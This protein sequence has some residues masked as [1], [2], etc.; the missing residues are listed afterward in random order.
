M[1]TDGS[2]TVIND[3]PLG[4]DHSITIN[5]DTVRTLAVADFSF[6]DTEGNALLEVKIV[7]LPTHGTIYYDA[8]GAGANAPVAI[9]AGQ[10]FSAA[11]L[12][13]GK[14]TYV[15]GQDDNGAGYATFTYQVRDNGGTAHGGFDTDPVPN[16][17]TVNV[18][19][20]ND[21]ATITGTDTGAVVESGLNP[22]NTP[23]PGTPTATGTLTVTDVDAG[24]NEL[25]PVT[26][27]TAGANGYGTF[28]VAANGTWTY[29]LDNSDSDTNKLFQGQVV[30]DSILVFSKDGTASHTVTV[31]ITGTNDAPDAVNDTASA[32]EDGAL[33]LGTVATNDTDVDTGATRTFAQVGTTPGLTFNSDG[34]YIFN[35]LDPAY[36]HIA[37]GATQTVTATYAATDEHGATDTATLTITVSGTNDAPVANADANT[38]VEDGAPVTGN[39]GTND[40][41]VDDGATRTY[42]LVG[43]APAGL[44]FNPNGSYSFDPTNAAYQHIAQGATQTV[45]ATY[46]ATDQ[47]GATSTTTLTITV[48]GTNDVPDA[49]NDIASAT[50]DGAS[51]IG[52]LATNDTDV[53]DGATRTFALSAPVAGLSL[54][55]NGG[56]NFVPSDPAYQHIAQ[57][58]TQTVTA[59]Y[60]ATDDHG[61]TD[62]A[63]LTITVTGVNDAPDAVDDT[64]SVNEDGG[65]ISGNV[66][67]NDTDV[68]DGAT[69]AFAVVGSAP[70]GLTFNP[71]GSYSFDPSNAAYQH[72]AQGVTQNVVTTYTITDDQ[73]A[74][75]TATLTITVTGTNDAPDAVNDTAS[76]TEDGSVVTGSVATNDTDVD[77]GATRT[78]ALSAPVAGLSLGSNGAYSFDPSDPA[79]QHIAQGTTQNVVVT[80]TATDDHGA[81]DT[82]TLTITVTGANDAPDA[83]N[84]T[85]SAAEDSGALLGSVATNDTDVDDGAT[86]TYALNAPVAGLTLVSNGIYSF[87]TSNAAYQHLADG[88]TQVVTAT[89]TATDDHGATDTATL[90]ITLTG[91]ND[92]PVA[93]ADTNVAVEDGSLVTGNVGANDS[94]AD[95]GATRTFALNAPV[96]G[97]TLNTDGS[98]SFNPANAAY[99][100]IALGATQTVTA[101]YTVTD[102]HGATATSTLTI[103]VVGAND[104]PDGVND[105]LAATEDG[106]VVTGSLA[107]NDTDA[108]DGAT[109]TYALLTPIAGLTVNANGSYS[110]NPAGS[111]YQSIADGDTRIQVAQY[112]VTDQFGATDVATLTITVTG[113]NDNPVAVVDTNSGDAVVEAGVNPADTPFAGDTTAS[114]NVLFNDTDID[115]G[116]TRTVSAVNGDG[117]NVGSTVAGTYGS[118][119]IGSDGSY[120]YTLDNNDSDTNA[121]AQGATAT[122]VFTYTM[123]DNHGGS[124][125]T[126]LTIT[127]TGTNDLPEV[128]AVSVSAD[129]DGSA[130]TASF[131]GDDVDND[132]NGAS[133]TYQI[134]STPSE[135][136]VDNNGD[137][138]FTFDPLSGF[139]DLAEGETRQVTFLYRATD[140][141]SGFSSNGTVTV[142]VTGINDA[143]VGSG[144]SNSA[145]EDGAVVTGN[146]GANDVDVDH[147]AILTYALDS[148]APAGLTFNPD[149][150]YSFDPADAAYQHLA[151]G[152][153]QNV[154]ASYTV[155]DDHGATGTA[156]LTITVTGVNDAPAAIADTN[157]AVEDGAVVTGNVGA[158]DT[159][160]DDG[161]TRTFA[162]N[163]PVAGLTLNSDGSYSFD[164]ANAAY[165]SL[166]A[167]AT[168]SV[169]AAYTV[170]DDHGAT[171]V[172]TLT[173]T[174]TGTDDAPIVH[175]DAVS[176]NEATVLNGNVFSNN[177]SGA[178]SDIDGPAL[179]VSAVNGN[180]RRGGQPD[181]ARLGRVADAECERHVQ[182]RSQ[183]CV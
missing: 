77:D 75:D 165:Q 83:V 109:R 55:S 29:T 153:T 66:G 10:T 26:A 154:T 151:A 65:T 138:T 155:T 108:D 44:T 60:I 175:P 131:S 170:T 51:V 132:D 86:R 50:E 82:A 84:D 181:H 178:D 105:T 32:T 128:Q 134:R 173:I 68:D 5:E 143:P 176:T 85:A 119:T 13:A 7:D 48:V 92:A 182:L 62:T 146:V 27:G 52:S 121:L 142:T 106:S 21:P 73:G 114:G 152:A 35:P 43:S 98:Y 20:V 156:T 23:F 157:V 100:H 113:V 28:Q 102:D 118:V 159:D 74:T 93:V 164:P 135:G 42:A 140:S 107:T 47:F 46:T 24:D 40:T 101:N 63:T 61:A 96:A 67:A 168:Q 37:Q 31:T 1:E 19:P 169:A 34:S 161:A 89:Y 123:V 36:Q 147:G 88:A 76:A 166:A 15:P 180:R 145:T 8:D 160:V 9:T 116:D 120:T 70:A 179:A 167:G 117:L 12:N 133:L 141:H 97:L 17:I 110:F 56:Y 149:G 122:D 3:A 99:Q 127:V 115:S 87:D 125:T 18:T 45:T 94:D 2:L 72:L 172:A 90:T 126:T 174:V 53:D 95:D 49:V 64:R 163:A 171:G 91:T 69:R 136:L 57:G 4:V 16:T 39:V 183:P 177:G 80:Y 41:D 78:F 139:Q 148:A 79:Y 130:V 150:S 81:T 11:D 25:V 111:S 103:T 38:A 59:T 162:L 33:V 129:E 58:A 144:D 112:R 54:V 124:S 6:T 137:G 14:L 71:D 22:A 30:T 104:A 158:N